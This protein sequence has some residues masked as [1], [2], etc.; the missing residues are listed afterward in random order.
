MEIKIEDKPYATTNYFS[1]E[2]S[3]GEFQT[4]ITII[5]TDESVDVCFVDD[6]PEDYGLNKEQLKAEIISQFQK[7]R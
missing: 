3:E 4:V 5:E 7:S 1:G 6:D 2:V